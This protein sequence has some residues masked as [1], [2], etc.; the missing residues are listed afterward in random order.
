MRIRR[1]D[2]VQVIAGDDAGP[3]VHRVIRVVDGGRKVLLEG[4]NQVY[5]HVR[6]GHPK[7]PQGGRLQMEMPID[8]SNV[9]LYCEP[10]GKGTRVGLRFVE[11]GRKERFCRSCG[12][13]AGEVGTAKSRRTK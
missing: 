12:A 11:E 10:C 6:R 9:L 4:V 5:K 3:A 1:G 7:S 2:S 13:A 8:T